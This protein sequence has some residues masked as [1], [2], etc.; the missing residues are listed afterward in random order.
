MKQS[1]IIAFSLL[2]ILSSCAE[3]NQIA[4]QTMGGA[5]PLP[6]NDIINGLKESLVQGASKSVNILAISDGYYKDELVKI[7]LPPEADIIVKNINKIPGGSQLLDDVLLKI[8]RAAEDAAKE[9]KPIFVNSIRSMNIADAFGILKGADN[10]ATAYLHKTTYEQ[11]FAL[12]KPKINTSLEKKL[13]SNISPNQSWDLLTGK[14]NEIANTIV[15][16]IA[17]F[18]PVN[19]KLDEYLTH[20]ALDGLFLKIQEEEMRIRKDP[21]ARTSELLRRVFARQD[22]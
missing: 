21:K 15:G 1:K 4:T 14:W 5:V 10:A 18:E 22:G 7:L 9:A 17:G 19:V 11:L 3:L 12:Y 8:N 13:V 6:Q 20:R 16:R 2:F